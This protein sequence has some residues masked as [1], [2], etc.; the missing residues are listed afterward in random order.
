MHRGRR[1]PARRSAT[2]G[3]F[4]SGDDAALHRGQLGCEAAHRRLDLVMRYLGDYDPA[5][6]EASLKGPDQ[7]GSRGHV[8]CRTGYVGF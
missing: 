1:Q 3:A 8:D 2:G 5:A 4:K 6:T 7:R